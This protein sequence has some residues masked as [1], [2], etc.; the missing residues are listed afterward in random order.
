LRE[1]DPNVTSSLSLEH[2]GKRV[3][4]R[5]STK[6][7]DIEVRPKVSAP[8][9]AEGDIAGFPLFPNALYGGM[10]T[11]SSATAFANPVHHSHVPQ[12]SVLSTRGVPEL[13]QWKIWPVRAF[14]LLFAIIVLGS[15]VWYLS[16]K[17]SHEA[18][19][20][21]ITR[22]AIDSEPD[23]PTAAVSLSKCVPIPGR[24]QRSDGLC[25]FP[26]GALHFTS[27]MLISVDG[28]PEAKLLTPD[29]MEQTAYHYPTQRNMALNSEEVPYIVLSSAFLHTFK[30][31]LGDM[32]VVTY[33]GKTAYAIVGDFGPDQADK[34]LVG[35]GSIALA[36]R[37]GF[38][39]IVNGRLVSLQEGVGYLIFPRSNR[40]DLTPV[41]A[42]DQISQ[43]GKR[44][45][46]T[47]LREQ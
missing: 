3:A 21:Q 12:S 18:T 43:S 39:P 32:C 42:R 26:S 1:G 30:V 24:T 40:N 19:P 46:E 33:N 7:R 6:Y 22:Q 23:T 35:E 44:L 8:D 25:Q 45:L 38:E 37:V 5:I 31:A 29:G 17:R 47:L 11:D 27:E 28:A 10:S 4:Q 9:E 20:K 2:V 13:M 34:P 14:T 15:G 41:D 36:R 16:W